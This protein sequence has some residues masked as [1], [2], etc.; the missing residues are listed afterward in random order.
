VLD[1]WAVLAL[2]QKEEPAASQVKR[3]LESAFAGDADLFMSIINLGEVIYRIGKVRGDAAAQE[4][5]AQIRRLLVTLVPATDDA[6]FSAV[7][8]KIQWPISYADAF[9]AAAAES[10]HATL[11]TGDVELVRLK[12]R[13]HIEELE[14]AA[15]PT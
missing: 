15:R 13:I 11:V 10:L 1:A 14:R 8:F 5:L 2:L 4:T 9:A 12:D 3:L 6:V 7:A